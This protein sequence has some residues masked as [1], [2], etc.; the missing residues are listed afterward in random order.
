MNEFQQIYPNGIGGYAQQLAPQGLLGGPV[1]GLVGSGI[2]SIFGNPGMGSQIGKIA[3]GIGGSLLPFSGFGLPD[4]LV[5]VG[6]Q[7]PMAVQAM[8]S[9]QQGVRVQQPMPSSALG[10]A[11]PY[12]EHGVRRAG[13]WSY[14]MVNRWCCNPVCGNEAR[15]NLTLFRQVAVRMLAAIAVQGRMNTCDGI[16]PPSSFPRRAAS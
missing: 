4:A 10:S 9:S 1:G 5:A 14:G 3:G 8:A 12:G 15:G 6:L 7:A 13:I 2:G 11:S 16:L